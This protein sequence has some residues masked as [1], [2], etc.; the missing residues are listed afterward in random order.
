MPIF[1]PIGDGLSAAGHTGLIEVGVWRNIVVRSR[2][3]GGAIGR[4]A[5]ERGHDR[6]FLQRHQ[7]AAWYILVGVEGAPIGLGA[8]PHQEW[9]EGD[10]GI[11]KY[12][13]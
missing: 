7:F 9:I 11:G 1:S 3:Y 13:R 5:I 8:F 4:H 2:G 10:L 6:Q 12:R